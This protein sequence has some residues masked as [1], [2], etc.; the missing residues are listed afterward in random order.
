MNDKNVPVTSVQL[1][2]P[3]LSEARL[4]NAGRLLT[5]PPQVAQAAKVAPALSAQTN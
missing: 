5:K 4:V 3:K 1:I 2:G